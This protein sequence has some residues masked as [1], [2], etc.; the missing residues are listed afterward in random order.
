METN[1]ARVSRSDLQVDEAVHFV[2]DDNDFIS[3]STPN[4]RN[5]ELSRRTYSKKN[6]IVHQSVIFN[7]PP[8][9]HKNEVSIR[10]IASTSFDLKNTTMP[11]GTKTL[12]RKRKKDTESVNSDSSLSKKLLK[13]NMMLKCKSTSQN[14]FTKVPRQPRSKS[15]D[16]LPVNND[17]SDSEI[18]V[19]AVIN[20]GYSEHNS[21]NSS[22]KK[23]S[24][25]HNSMSSKK[26]NKSF[27]N[28]AK[29]QML[30]NEA[31]KAP[32]MP[33]YPNLFS[34]VPS[35]ANSMRWLSANGSISVPGYSQGFSQNSP[36]P[37]ERC[38]NGNAQTESRNVLLL[39]EMKL[40]HEKRPK[41]KRELKK[42]YEN[43]NE[44]AWAQETSFKNLLRS[45]DYIR[46]SERSTGRIAGTGKNLRKLKR[47]ENPKG[48]KGKSHTAT[49]LLARKKSKIARL[50]Y[51][52]KEKKFIR[53]K[54]IS[55]TQNKRKVAKAATISEKK[56]P[57][58]KSKSSATEESS[59]EEDKIKYKLAFPL[60]KAKVCTTKAKIVDNK[61]K[62]GEGSKIKSDLLKINSDA[63]KLKSNVYKVKSEG[64]KTKIDVMKV[65]SY[66]P[67]IKPDDSPPSTS[68]LQSGTLNNNKNNSLSKSSDLKNF[69]KKVNTFAPYEMQLF[70]KMLEGN[71][72]FC[73]AVQK[74]SKLRVRLQPLECTKLWNAEFYE[75]FRKR[76]FDQAFRK[77]VES[78]D[79]NS[80]QS[81]YQDMMESMKNQTN[82]NRITKKK[83]YEEDSLR[84]S[85]R[86]SEGAFK[87]KEIIVKKQRNYMQVVLVP[88]DIRQNSLTIEAL[89]EL[90][91]AFLLAKRDS[92]CHAVLL[93]SSGSY[94]CTGV[95]LSP[96]IGSNKKQAAEE[97]ANSMNELV[98]T[99][100]MFTKP[101][102]AAVNGTALGFGVSLLTYCDVVFASDKATFCLPAARI[103]Y[104]PEGGI[105]LTLPQVVG[106]SVATEMLLQGRRL[107]AEQA[108]RCGLVSEVLWP[109]SLLN[110]VMPRLEKIISKPL[111]G[112]LPQIWGGIEPNRTVTCMGL[113][114]MANDRRH[115]DL[116]HEEFCDP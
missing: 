108:C 45:P 10:N 104:V 97:L 84:T 20:K 90:K 63:Q 74:G 41:G 38:E 43:L 75:E 22:V 9:R 23:F 95:D 96:L 54:L 106:S 59:S 49:N 2:L 28:E 1:K 98:L 109:T 86:Q 94:F 13:K 103:G 48:K 77:A 62:N 58:A 14:T 27:E 39:P 64:S 88:N 8:D 35:S 87:Y 116:C 26:I 61:V 52:Q 18:E 31:D 80:V 93:N 29:K 33:T 57:A 66:V 92:N 3:T 69:I 115:L 25:T 19:V 105:T 111:Q 15:V 68:G 4:D 44:I 112:V 55:E 107:T 110:Q 47:K 50:N 100:S 21:N 6:P 65:K 42:L 72:D 78:K 67:Q 36:R 70:Q 56:K 81:L 5:I 76:I 85:V 37:Q 12:L 32:L 7:K 24:N 101:V 53:N 71:E 82:S 34:D 60:P 16:P 11:S 102:I 73:S 17:G 114:A 99:L 83:R 51:S 30:V 113:K 46:H 79:Y 40:N 89:K 91:D